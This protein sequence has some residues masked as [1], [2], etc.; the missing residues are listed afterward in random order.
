MSFQRNPEYLMLGVFA[1][2]IALLYLVL[3]GDYL[4]GALVLAGIYATV[5]LGI[6]L[7]AGL[8]GQYSLGHAAFFGIGAYAS[9]L[10]S[11][12][13]VPVVAS[14]LLATAVTTVFAIIIGVPFLRLKGYYLALATLAFGLIVLS[15]LNGWHGFTMG[16]SGL[17]GI[18]KFEVAG[19]VFKSEDA[20][21]WLVW[22]IAFFAVWGGINL[23]RS[24]LGQALLAVKRDEDGAA[25]VGINVAW[26]KLQVFALSAALA[27]LGGALYAHY[28][29][30]IAPERFNMVASF[31][32]LLAALLGGIGTPFGAVFGALLLVALPE[33]VVLLRDYKVI[34]YGLVFILVSLYLPRGVAGLITLPFAGPRPKLA[35]TE[36]I[37]VATIAPKCTRKE[38]SPILEVLNV[39]KSFAGLVALNNIS[40]AVDARTVHGVIGPNG[41]GKTTLF[42]VIT[43]VFPPSAGEVRFEG[44]RISGIPAYRVARL[45]VARTFQNVRL[46][47]DQTVLENVVIGAYRNTRAGLV[48]GALRLPSAAVEEV[49][50]RSEAMECLRFVGLD[51]EAHRKA[52]ILPFGQQRLLEF[53]RALALRP[54]LLLLDEPAAGLNDNETEQLAKLISYLPGRG[55]TVLLVEHNMGFMMSVADRIVVLNYGTKIA[56]GDPDEIQ[57]NRDVVSAYL[58]APVDT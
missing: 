32:L 35:P 2:G 48:T 49:G 40:F 21:Y 42:N 57:D 25:A 3:R 22:A 12:V 18:P 41:A 46:F 47:G 4:L 54:K 45:G 5:I 6:V 23:W 10:M 8:S 50:V 9:A 16:P 11:L 20:N 14:C 44:A 51:A 15:V 37:L 55:I 58:G 19:L 36:P 13:G 1:A 52:E 38:P 39:G 28:I 27:G 30:F 31:E 53:A 43:S 17:G 56:E 7:L 34:V 24:R 33:I 26:V 29:T